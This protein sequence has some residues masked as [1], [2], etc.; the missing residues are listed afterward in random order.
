MIPNNV[1]R[2]FQKLLVAILAVTSIST[3]SFAG[4]Y[5]VV[6]VEFQFYT[7]LYQFMIYQPNL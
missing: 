5:Y 4:T 1:T 3:A 6:S 2:Y 7:V